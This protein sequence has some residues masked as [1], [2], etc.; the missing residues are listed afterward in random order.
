MYIDR[1]PGTTVPGRFPCYRVHRRRVRHRYTSPYMNQW[2]TLNRVFGKYRGHAAVLIALG[3]VGAILDG[4]AINIAIPS[5]SFLVNPGTVPTDFISKAVAAVFGFFGIPFTFRHLIFLIT[6]LLFI[7]AGVLV[8]FGYVRGWITG[9]FLASES[10]EVLGSTLTASWSFLL[11]QKIGHIQN[12]IERDLQRSANL[13]ESFSQ[14]IQSATGFL[15]YLLVALNISAL[16]TLFTFIAGI[17]FTLI[18]RPF[19]KRTQRFGHEMAVTDKRVSQFVTEHI[20]GMK[21]V[22]AAGV[23]KEAFATGSRMFTRLHELFIRIAFVRSISTA[24]FQ[25]FAMVFVIVLFTLTYRSGSFDIIAFAAT[26]YLI[27]KI[28]TY[29]E[30][31]QAS[32]HGIRELIPYALNVGEFKEELARVTEERD[33]GTKDFALTDRIDFTDVSFSYTDRA[34]VLEGV[35][36]CIP[37]GTTTAIIGPS[38]AGKTSVADLMLRLFEPTAGQITVDGVPLGDISL[39]SLRRSLGY[40]AQDSFLLN[41][42]IKD[43]IRFY[44]A[45]LTDADIDRALARANLPE[46]IAG[47]PEGIDTLVGDRGVMLSGG[48]RQRVALARAL[49]GTPSLL[50]LDEATS[51]LDRESERLVQESIEALHGMV[52]VLVIAHRLST[53]E[54]ADMIVVLDG[55]KVIESG[56]PEELRARPDSYYA[57]H[58]A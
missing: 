51:A 10:K 8:V 41:A 31:T 50:I 49:A 56:R 23:E 55:G 6:G 12:T 36:F 25:P 21:A 4:L 11:K 46:V 28:F 17:V 2:A 3:L 27:Q 26:L 18:F 48:Q 34:S 44:R 30:S 39:T 58:S 5:I 24:F 47:L 29:L 7:R 9:D 45:E 52:T 43:N 1:R 42:S 22:K 53:I 35:T 13:L 57:R 33:T 37:A 40:V 20:I 14:L 38:G 16:T 19:L 54:G 15:M 32:L